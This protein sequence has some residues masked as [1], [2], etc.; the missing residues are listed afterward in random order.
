MP[1]PKE[2]GQGE[3]IPADP[4]QPPV[5]EEPPAVLTDDALDQ[6]VGGYY[7]VRNPNSPFD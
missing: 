7:P 1:D 2:K 6:V 5:P 3:D 4:T